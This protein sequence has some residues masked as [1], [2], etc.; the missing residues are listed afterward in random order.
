MCEISGGIVWFKNLTLCGLIL[1]HM[2]PTHAPCQYMGVLWPGT[3]CA[4][5]PPSAVPVQ[6]SVGPSQLSDTLSFQLLY[7]EVS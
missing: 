6:M 4:P 3:V 7:H 1:L 2:C 5:P